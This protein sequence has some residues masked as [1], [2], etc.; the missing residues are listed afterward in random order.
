MLTP[1]RPTEW[2]SASWWLTARRPSSVK[3]N[4]LKIT[5]SNLSGSEH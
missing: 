5:L 2:H 1:D 4:A 3:V